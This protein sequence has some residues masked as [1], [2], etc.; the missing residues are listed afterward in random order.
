ML[1]KSILFIATLFVNC[2]IITHQKLKALL[3]E[4]VMTKFKNLLTSYL[5]KY[6]RLKTLTLEILRR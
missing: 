6:V 1:K 3:F 4:K 5:K 2:V